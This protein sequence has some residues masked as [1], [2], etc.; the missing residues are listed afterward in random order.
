MV[1]WIWEAHMKTTIEISDTLLEA[2]R[3]LAAREGTSL[4]ALVEQ[5]L[6]RLLDQRRETAPFELRKVSFKG[7]GLQPGVRE[8]S[9]EE[10]R[11]RVYRGRGS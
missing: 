6:R 8:G 9:W 4:R 5:G 1:P 11:D 10:L 2:A 3:E 7:R